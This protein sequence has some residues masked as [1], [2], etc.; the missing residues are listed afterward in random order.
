MKKIPILLFLF[1]SIRFYSQDI[2][3][4]YVNDFKYIIGNSTAET[5][6]LTYA[7]ENGFNYLILYNLTYIHLYNFQ[8]DN[9]LTSTPL[10]NFIENA[11]TNYGILEVGA[12]GEKNSS[13]D[14]IK[15]YNSF[16]PTEPNKRFDVFN[17]EFEFWNTSLVS[18]TNYYCTTYLTPNGYPCTINGAFDYYNSQLTLLKTYCDANGIKAETYIGYP[19]A[20]QSDAIVLNTHRVLVHYYRSSDVY[21]NGDSIYQYNSTRIEDLAQNPV[22]IMPIFSARPAHMY[23]WLTAPHPL[24]QPFNTFINGTNGYNDQ[25]GAWKTNV[26]FDGYVWYRYT[27]LL[28]IDTVLSVENNAIE[29]EYLFYNSNERTLHFLNFDNNSEVKIYGINGLKVMDLKLEEIVPITKTL[30]GIYIVKVATRKGVFVQK[31]LI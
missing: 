18:P 7:Q 12:V 13:F 19:N 28:E 26:T 23:S 10:A 11:K 1:I 16:Y 31:I 14:K 15:I 29:N 24:T 22:T 20:T 17:V 6:L 27:D 2:V 3:G 30:K 8:I 21:N 9:I 4:L 25:T 5:E